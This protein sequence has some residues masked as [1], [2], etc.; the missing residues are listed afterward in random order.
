MARLGF[1]TCA[2][3]FLLAA[4][5][6]GRGQ[7]DARLVTGARVRVQW[8]ETSIRERRASGTLLEFRPDSLA[9]R[10]RAGV[11]RFALARLHQIDVR[12]PRARGW[13]AARGAWVGALAGFGAG[14]VVGAYAAG[15]C[16]GDMCALALIG[17]PILGVAAGLPL[18]ILVGAVHPGQ[19][20]QRVR[21]ELRGRAG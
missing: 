8:M 20:W 16:D 21:W 11:R 19:R 7:E 10:H 13:G 3:V 12:V 1:S 2:L 5:T 4:P 17:G 9:L 18:G 6:V 14:L 15:T